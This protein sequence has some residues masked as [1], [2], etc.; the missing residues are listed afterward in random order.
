MADKRGKEKGMERSSSGKGLVGGAGGGKEM[1]ERFEEMERRWREREEQSR[2]ERE[3]LIKTVERLEGK[4]KE[5]EKRNKWKRNDLEK[6]IGEWDEGDLRKARNKNEVDVLRRCEERLCEA[7]EEKDVGKVEDV[8]RWLRER[9][10]LVFDAEDIG[11]VRACKA[12]GLKSEGKGEIECYRCGKKGH[13]SSVCK[14]RKKK[15][16]EREESS[17]SVSSSEESSEEEKKRKKKKKKKKK[18]K[19][20]KEKEESSEEEEEEEEEKGRGGGKKKG[21]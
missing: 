21:E 10:D 4:L 8:V 20:R 12:R 16:R 19:V 1:E 3:E 11:W 5:G 15:K 17:S 2:R 18:R 6:R 7:I 13:V 9:A 14:A